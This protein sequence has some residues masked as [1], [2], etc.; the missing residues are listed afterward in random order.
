MCDTFYENMDDGELNGVVFLNICK[1]FDSLIQSLWYWN[2]ETYQSI[3]SR[4]YLANNIQ[5]FKFRLTLITAHP[6]G[7]YVLRLLKIN[8][9]NFKT[10]QQK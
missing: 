9:K 7:E 2:D 10:V 6:Y 8:F 5:R 1:A 3:C 4:L